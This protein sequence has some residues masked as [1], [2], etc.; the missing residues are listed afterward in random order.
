MKVLMWLNQLVFWK[1]FLNNVT[2]CILNVLVIFL[3]QQDEAMSLIQL[4]FDWKITKMTEWHSSAIQLPFQTFPLTFIVDWTTASPIHFSNYDIYL[5]RDCTIPIFVFCFV[6][7]CGRT[8]RFIS[9]TREFMYC[10]KQADFWRGL[11]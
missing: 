6:R 3:F 9:I 5:H 10:K 1:C 4:Q 2:T 8:Y 11:L 7:K